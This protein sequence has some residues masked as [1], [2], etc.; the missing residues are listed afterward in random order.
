MFVYVVYFSQNI[1]VIFTNFIFLLYNLLLPLQYLNIFIL[2]FVLHLNSLILSE[3]IVYFS[4]F[5]FSH[6][7]LLLLLL[8]Y[9]VS[10]F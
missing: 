7:V 4:H 10:Q 6:Y 1:S 3:I 8:F 2:I 9:L 5:I